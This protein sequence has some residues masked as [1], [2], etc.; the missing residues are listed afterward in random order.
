[1]KRLILLPA[2]ALVGWATLAQPKPQ[3]VTSKIEKVTVFAQGAQVLRKAVVAL[4]A[5]KTELV[6]AGISPKIDKQSVQVKGQGNFTI[7]SV[8]HQTNY[9]NEQQ[10][11]QEIEELQ[12]QKANLAKRLKVEKST[13]AVFK[14]EQEI[15]AKNQAIGGDNT[16]LKTADLKEA[17][18]F[19]R[20]RLSEVLLKQLDIEANI[21]RLDSSVAKL[22]QQLGA[23]NQS[24][25]FATSEVLVTVSAPE[26]ATAPFELTYLVSE[27]GWFANYDLRVKD[28]ASPI[29]LTLKANLYQT[30]GEDWK[31]IKLSV[32]S[33][34]PTESGMAPVLPAWYLRFGY[35]GVADLAQ[36]LQGR[37]AGLDISSKPGQLVGQV[38][39]RATGQPLPGVNVVIKGTTVGTVTDANGNFSLQSTGGAQTLTLSYVGYKSLEVPVRAGFMGIGLAEDEAQ[40]NEVVVSGYSGNSGKRKDR[41]DARSSNP[42]ETIEKYQPTTLTFDIENPYTILNDGKNYTADLKRLSIPALYEYFAVPKLAKEA[43]LTAKIIDWQELN[44]LTGEVNLFFEGAYLGKSLLEVE[45]AADTLSISLGKDKSVVVDRKKLKEFSSKQFLSN[46]QTDSRSYELSVRNNRPQGIKIV[47]QDQYPI[48]TS[49]DITVEEQEAKDAQLDPTTKILRW[50]YELAPRQERKHLLKYSVKYPKNQVLVLD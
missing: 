17:V 43:F 10:R 2:L 41:D 15:L 18:D 25:D 50:Q 35:P 47:V 1:M 28:I 44:L 26:R 37:V 24:R 27:A 19:Q 39:E 45:R 16:G 23:L 4:P 29:D 48:S 31:D 22:N 13:L 9:L 33:G 20:D 3:V 30:S 14:N 5:G 34:N 46:Y 38:F 32:S 8:V 12:S 6:F 21:A 49:K 42:L 36:Q 40:L 7:L 11:R